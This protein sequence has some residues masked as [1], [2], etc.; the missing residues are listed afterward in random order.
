MKGSLLVAIILLVVFF[1]AGIIYA[2]MM[3]SGPTNICPQCQSDKMVPEESPR[4]LDILSKKNKPKS[5]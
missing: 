2:I 5:K 1:P 3:S 4:A